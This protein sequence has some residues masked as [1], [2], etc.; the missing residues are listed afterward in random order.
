MSMNSSVRDIVPNELPRASSVLEIW[1]LA[2]MAAL[3]CA[4]LFWVYTFA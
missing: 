3:M 4:A 1:M 2:L